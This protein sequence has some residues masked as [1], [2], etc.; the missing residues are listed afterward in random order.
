MRKTKNVS[1]N[2]NQ[3]AVKKGGDYASVVGKSQ[4]NDEVRNKSE[5]KQHEDKQLKE[6][7]NVS[8]VLYIVS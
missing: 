6:S 7:S 1:K 8:V 5:L 3:E 4:S 2:S